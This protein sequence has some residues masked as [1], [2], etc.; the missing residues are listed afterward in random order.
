MKTDGFEEGYVKKNSTQKRL[1]GEPKG[2]RGK[3]PRQAAPSRDE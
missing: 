2:A 1:Y 3:K